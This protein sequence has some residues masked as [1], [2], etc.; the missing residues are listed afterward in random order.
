MSVLILSC[1]QEKL[2]P[3]YFFGRQTVHTAYHGTSKI[4]HGNWGFFLACRCCASHHVCRCSECISSH[5]Y[6]RTQAS[7]V[8]CLRE[9]GEAAQLDSSG[10][11]LSPERVQ[12]LARIQEATFFPRKTTLMNM[13]SATHQ[14]TQLPSVW[15]S[16]TVTALP[17]HI[18]C[19]WS[20]TNQAVTTGRRTCQNR[21]PS[22]TPPNSALKRNT[23]GSVLA[24]AFAMRRKNMAVS[25]DH[26][27]PTSP[28]DNQSGPGSWSHQFWVCPA[29][30]VDELRGNHSI[31]V[32]CTERG[33]WDKKK[34]RDKKNTN[35]T[36]KQHLGQNK[37]RQTGQKKHIRDKKKKTTNGTNKTWD[38]LQS[39]VRIKGPREV[40]RGRC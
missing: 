23:R 12:F 15:D 33:C 24:S 34:P 8:T 20:V 5:G 40:G 28:E 2:V 16:Q 9:V 39:Q 32:E 35:G 13:F 22:R 29:P 26:L 21:S 7:S 11:C 27:P 14:L 37:T 38:S 30:C 4:L 1:L 10:R 3:V 19:F 18:V 17:N 6:S 25:A 31:A 36:K